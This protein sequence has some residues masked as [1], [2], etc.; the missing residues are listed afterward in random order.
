MDFQ[1]LFVAL[2]IS[3]FSSR[4][5]RIFRSSCRRDTLMKSTDRD[6]KLT[7]TAQD[8]IS[9]NHV[10]GARYCVR[11]CTKELGCV[12]V[13]FKVTGSSEQEINCQLLRFAKSEG[14]L[15]GVPGWRHY[16]PVFHVNSLLIC[17]RY[18]LGTMTDD[19]VNFFTEHMSF[20]FKAGCKALVFL[21]SIH[22]HLVLCSF[23]LSFF[24]IRQSFLHCRVF[25]FCQLIFFS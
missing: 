5:A 18:H 22:W 2:W 9:E 20:S 12:S 15:T 7:G 19:F 25:L 24:L 16:E 10:A 4:E 17:I 3:W 8:I 1:A 14:A 6:K 23:K 11:L 13:N 21:N